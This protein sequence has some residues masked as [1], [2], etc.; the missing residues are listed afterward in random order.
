M[1]GLLGLSIMTRPSVEGWLMIERDG[2][3][4][5]EDVGACYWV[6]GLGIR[7][8]GRLGLG[9]IRFWIWFTGL[10]LG[11]RR[12]AALF[13]RRRN[14]LGR[15]CSTKSWPELGQVA[16]LQWWKMN[17]NVKY[18]DDADAGFDDRTLE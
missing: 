5:G 13:G 10:G 4:E 12:C 18:V 2:L 7:V 17:D 1:G 11:P 9:Q 14:S 16:G 8:R 6:E 15:C 3:Y